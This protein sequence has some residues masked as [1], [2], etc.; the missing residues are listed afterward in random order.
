MKPTV[1]WGLSGPSFVESLEQA[2]VGQGS[3]GPAELLCRSPGSDRPARARRKSLRT[4]SYRARIEGLMDTSAFYARSSQGGNPIG[5]AQ[6]L[7]SWRDSLVEAGWDGGGVLGGGERLAALA[8]IEAAEAIHC[9]WRRPIGWRAY[10]ALSLLGPFRHGFTMRSGWLKS[11]P[12]GLPAGDASSSSWNH[13]ARASQASSWYC[14]VRRGYGPRLV[15]AL[16]SGRARE[17]DR[18]VRRWIAATAEQ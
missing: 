18:S 11:I 7:L 16:D 3:W 8:A 14:L 4:P 12:C 5:T 9:R 1:G 15:A 6:T 17:H 13:R 10:R 2:R